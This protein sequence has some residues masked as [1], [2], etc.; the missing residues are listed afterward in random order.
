MVRRSVVLSDS[1]RPGRPSAARRGFTLIELIMVVVIIGLVSAIAL[2]RINLESY[3]V[4]SAVQGVTSALS[5]AQRLAVSLQTDVRVAFDVP[6]ERL[7]IHEDANNNGT[8]DA[9][10]RVTYTNLSDGVVFGMGGAPAIT[11]STGGVGATDI[12][13]TKTQGAFPVIV[14]RRDGSASENGGF[15]L[16]TRK[17][18]SSGSTKQSRAAEVI[19]ATGRVIWYNYGSGAWTRGN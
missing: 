8:I 12:N 3:K 19:R 15:Y 13:L 11:Y 16:T 6:N 7:R 1:S 10:E 9:G 5:Y 4:S 14:F 17:A 18:I 2:P